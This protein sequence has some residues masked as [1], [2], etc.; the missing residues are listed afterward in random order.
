MRLLLD[1]NVSPLVA[2]VLTGSGHDAVHVRDLGLAGAPD[3]HVLRA[4]AASDRTLVSNDTDF[5]A[6]LARP[7]WTSPSVVLLRRPTGRRA[8]DVAALISDVLFAEG[9][10]IERGALVVVSGD[11]LKTRRLPIDPW[12]RRSAVCARPRDKTI[13]RDT[14]RLIDQANSI[15]GAEMGSGEVYEQRLGALVR[16]R[17]PTWALSAYKNV[18]TRI[19]RGEGSSETRRATSPVSI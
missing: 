1:E 15:S 10:E 12:T 5:G 7:S 13:V 14:N 19:R 3:E 16:E 2:D 8:S 18:V 6:L 17:C 9:D 11:R 4:A